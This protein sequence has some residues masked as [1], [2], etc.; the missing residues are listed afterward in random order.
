MSTNTAFDRIPRY[1]DPLP[2]QIADHVALDHGA[3]VGRDI[4]ATAQAHLLAHARGE[5][6]GGIHFH[7]A[8]GD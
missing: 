2:E 3:P 5:F 4:V 6:I 1:P 8:A 7:E